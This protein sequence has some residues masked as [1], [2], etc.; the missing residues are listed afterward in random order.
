M[1]DRL[2]RV[3]LPDSLMYE[4]VLQSAFFL[5]NLTNFLIFADVC[6]LCF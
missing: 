3:E 1:G 4:A 2:E 5:T 6:L